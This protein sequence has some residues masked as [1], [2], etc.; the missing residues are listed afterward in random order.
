MINDDV[1]DAVLPVPELEVLKDETVAE[2]QTEGFV[3]TNF[4]SGGIFYTLLMVALRIK[5]ELTQLLRSILSNLFISHATGV[6]LDLKAADYS[7]TRK[8]AQKTQGVVTVSRTASGEAITI[9]KGQVFKTIK[10]INGDEL[11]FFALEDTVLQKDALSVE[12]P[13]E[14]EVEGTDYNVPVGQITRTLTYISGIDTI[15]NG[16]DWVTR[17]GT[18][19]EDDDSLRERCLRSW[20][21]LARVPIKDTYVNTCEAITGV[22]YA[23]V[24]DQHPRGQGTIDIVITSEAGSATETLLETVRTACEAIKQPDT[25]ILI[26]SAETV[27]QPITLTVTVLSSVNQDGID[28][29]VQS[30]ITNLL[31]ISRNRTLNELTHA[32]IIYRVKRDISTIRNVTITEPAEDMFLT[33][34]KVILPGIITV[35]VEEV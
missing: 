33:A 28:T 16:E 21:E 3:L 15:A 7:K 5:I 17:E 26:M 4:N 22:L 14:A 35:T 34:D 29:Q 9:P 20:S 13:V 10:D 30:S 19:T 2:L 23:T 12:V 31:K 18:D 27:E 24:N 8:A 6:W 32:D 25:D 11:R 1:L